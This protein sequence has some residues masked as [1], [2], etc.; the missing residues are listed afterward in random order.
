M[1]NTSASHLGS[2]L[3]KDTHNLSFKFRK[4]EGQQDAAGME[5]E[6]ATLGQ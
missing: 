3:M 6:I 1:V 2:G 4:F 5:D